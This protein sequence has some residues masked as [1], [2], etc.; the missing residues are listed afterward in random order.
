MVNVSPLH[1]A[2]YIG[3]VEIFQKNSI[4][5]FLIS[6]FFQDDER[7]KTMNFAVYKQLKTFGRLLSSKFT[8]KKFLLSV[9]FVITNRCNSRCSYCNTYNTPSEEMTTR[10]IFQMIDEFSDLGI[11][12]IGFT[13]GEPLLREDM[14]SIVS[15][16]HQKGIT[17]TLFSNG[18]LVPKKIDGLKHL[19]LLLLSLDGPPEIHDTVRGMKGSFNHVQNAIR[20]AHETQLPVWINA[21]ITKGNVSQL[22]FLI[23]F[24]VDN[25]VK[26]MFMPVF[27]HTLSAAKDTIT[28]L[29]ADEASFKGAINHL[30]VQKKKGAPIVNSLS[31]FQYILQNWPDTNRLHC[32]AG[33]N[34]CAVGSDGT[35]YPCHFFIGSPCGADG[36]RLGFRNA[37]ESI[38]TPKCKGCFCNAYIELN[39]FI[40]GHLNVIWNTVKHMEQRRHRDD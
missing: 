32:R 22:P 19:D 37:F 5:P 28:H 34:F 14:G 21:V 16:A 12:R 18:A 13:G 8:G 15:Y 31:Y 35:V 3:V 29:S 1:G 9:S 27:D 24:A 17:T 2:A 20:A 33:M 25:H 6:T 26:V 11:R 30:I 39:L 36:R 38:R 23:D 4:I 7:R 10:E 40:A